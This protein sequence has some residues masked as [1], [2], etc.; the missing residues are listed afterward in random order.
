MPISD[1]VI[2]SISDYRCEFTGFGNLDL[3][4]SRESHPGEWIPKQPSMAFVQGFCSRFGFP[5]EDLS[6]FL[7][8]TE[9]MMAFF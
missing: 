1:A 3:F 2:L 6:S 4:E 9:D 7:F 8:G 5:V